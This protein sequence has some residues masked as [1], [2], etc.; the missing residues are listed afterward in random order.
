MQYFSQKQGK[1][2]ETD[3][4]KYKYGLREQWQILRWI[5][6]LSKCNWNFKANASDGFQGTTKIR[7]N[8]ETCKLQ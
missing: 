5:F 4:K 2:D 3:L 7:D 6:E 8:W 1:T